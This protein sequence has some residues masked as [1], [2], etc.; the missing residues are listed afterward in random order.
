VNCRLSGGN[1]GEGGTWM[2]DKRG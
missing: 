1:G 2:I